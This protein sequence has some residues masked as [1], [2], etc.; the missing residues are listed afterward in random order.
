MT[1]PSSSTPSHQPP[2]KQTGRRVLEGLLALDVK[3]DVERCAA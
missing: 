1:S 2:G 3:H